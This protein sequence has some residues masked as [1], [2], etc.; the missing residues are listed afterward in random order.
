MMETDP[1]LLVAEMYSFIGIVLAAVIFTRLA[2][3]ARSIG[4]F[5]FQLSIFILIWVAAE[6]PHTL[7]S[8]G[9]I[10]VTS[11]LTVGLVLHLISMIVFA[12]FVGLRS[13]RFLHPPHGGAEPFFP[14]SSL[15]GSPKI[16]SLPRNPKGAVDQ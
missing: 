5:R 7:D 3:K 12:V 2:V 11:Y 15:T 4:N 6:V 9:L 8:L 13:L 16:P 10:D 14:E 1:L